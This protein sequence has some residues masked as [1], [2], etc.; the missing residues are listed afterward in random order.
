MLARVRDAFVAAASSVVHGAVVYLDAGAQAAV[1]RVGGLELLADLGAAQVFGFEPQ[2]GQPKGLT[3]PAVVLVTQFVFDIRDRLG[4]LLSL[5]AFSSVTILTTISAEAHTSAGDAASDGF[6]FATVGSWLLRGNGTGGHG[7]AGPRYATPIS[8]QH[9][10]LHVQLLVEN[11]LVADAGAIGAGDSASVYLAA[12]FSL[13]DPRCRHVRPLTL[14]RLH[15]HR[16]RAGAAASSSSGASYAGGPH[17]GLQ[18]AVQDVGAE[19]LPPSLRMEYRL[20]AHALVGTITTLQLDAATHVFG[21]GKT[22]CLVGNTVA[23]LLHERAA[24]TPAVGS[25]KAS[26]VLVDRLTDLLT[27]LLSLHLTSPGN[28]MDQIAALQEIQG[29]Q[30]GGSVGGVGAATGADGVVRDW[31]DT[32]ASVPC[33]SAVTTPL[34][35]AATCCSSDDFARFLSRV[36]SHI[37]QEEEGVT[38]DG[39]AHETAMSELRR[40]LAAVVES[41]YSARCRYN[42]LVRLAV[43]TLAAHDATSMRG[44]GPVY[45]VVVA[46]AERMLLQIASST[47]EFAGSSAQALADCCRVVIDAAQSKHQVPVQALLALTANAYL[48]SGCFGTFCAC[49]TPVTVVPQVSGCF[50]CCCCCYCWYC[51]RSY[52]MLSGG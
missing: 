5:N 18:R 40:V 28:T 33:P 35:L 45:R 48:V 10:P 7:A 14:A 2:D 25:H 6:D 17:M 43:L 15:V 8:A 49:G 1:D 32:A 13:A 38:V 51:V 52:V 37:L 19:D 26:L 30:Y 23:Q 47:R 20:L 16:S 39:D 29:P 12:A 27:P 11:P 41:S 42:P 36:L 21:L 3:G 4:E 31:R 46:Q 44:T 34:L 22:S 50:C 24:S 9:I